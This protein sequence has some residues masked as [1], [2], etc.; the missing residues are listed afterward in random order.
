MPWVLEVKVFSLF[1]IHK[2]RM[3]KVRVLLI[4]PNLEVLNQIRRQILNSRVGDS[5]TKRTGMLII[6]FRGLKKVVLVPLRM[7]SLK[8]ATAGA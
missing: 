7:V 8:R 2:A 6:P 5:H 3:S 4:P 1:N